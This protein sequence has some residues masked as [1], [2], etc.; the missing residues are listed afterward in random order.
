MTG[1]YTR[2]SRRRDQ[3]ITPISWEFHT[4]KIKI[5][6]VVLVQHGSRDIR[7]ISTRIAFSSDINFEILDTK[8]VLEVFEEMNEILG[9]LLLCRRCDFSNRESS[10]DGLLDP[11]RK[12]NHSLDICSSR[13]IGLDGS[14]TYHSMLV[15]LT[16]ELNQISL[17]RRRK[18]LATD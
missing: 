7:N 6:L 4:G 8:G 18:S 17:H 10:T 9:N 14:I 16:H 15:K 13:C 5:S 11:A 3:H 12:L 2:A 1:S